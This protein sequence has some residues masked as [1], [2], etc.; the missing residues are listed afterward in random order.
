MIGIP[1]HPKY[2]ENL[3]RT[4]NGEHQPCIV[5]GR[6]IKSEACHMVH[7][8]RGGTHLVTEE[9]AAVLDGASDLGLYP[10]GP[11][12]L[13]RHPEIKPYTR[14]AQIREE[15]MRIMRE[16]RDAAEQGRQ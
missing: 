11:C 13:R 1:Y 4:G 6:G 3:E 15:A 16:R 7:V 12:C 5:C 2:H 9:E 10:I 14:A 8:H